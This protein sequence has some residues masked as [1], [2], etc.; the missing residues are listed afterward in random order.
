M[1]RDYAPGEM[2]EYAPIT[3][4]YAWELTSVSICYPQGGELNTSLF[5]LLQLFCTRSQLFV[6]NWLR[7]VTI[8]VVLSCTTQD[9]VNKRLCVYTS[10]II[11]DKSPA[12]SRPSR[13]CP[14]LRGHPTGLVF[15][16]SCP[17][18]DGWT[19]LSY[20]APLTGWRTFWR[21]R[22]RCSR[23]LWFR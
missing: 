9:D 20:A 21:W 2:I 19:G 13:I 8:S 15:G 7:S 6:V 4:S 5:R 16:G 3:V 12:P 17:A 14:E 10:Q 1:K 22:K 11:R 23:R 18:E